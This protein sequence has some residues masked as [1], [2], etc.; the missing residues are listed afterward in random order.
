MKFFLMI[1]GA[2]YVH[3][4]IKWNQWYI[5]KTNLPFWGFQRNIINYVEIVGDEAFQ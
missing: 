1:I 3:I 5:V 4:Y 2:F